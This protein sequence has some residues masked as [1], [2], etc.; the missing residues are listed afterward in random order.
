MSGGNDIED[1][2]TGIGYP[3][4]IKICK[5]RPDVRAQHI[6]G[7]AKKVAKRRKKNKNKKTH[8]KL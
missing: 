3:S 8:R 2:L 6:K 4:W 1:F 7:K 5:P